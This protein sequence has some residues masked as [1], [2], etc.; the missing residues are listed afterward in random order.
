M[1]IRRRHLD[2]PNVN[3][4]S[5]PELKDS[6]VREGTSGPKGQLSA[7]SSPNSTTKTIRHQRV[8]ERRQTV[9]IV[10]LKQRADIG[11]HAALSGDL[12]A[13]LVQKIR[14]PVCGTGE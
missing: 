9:M 14:L 8:Y 2:K 5:D 3:V 1:P 4:G 7:I 11:W 6:V 13:I 12:S 10:I